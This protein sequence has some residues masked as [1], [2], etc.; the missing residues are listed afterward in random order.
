MGSYERSEINSSCT[1]F[2]SFE[3]IFSN[4]NSLNKQSH[5]ISKKRQFKSNNIPDDSTLRKELF[6]GFETFLCFYP[7]KQ[8][9]PYE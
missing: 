5:W 6:S 9:D 2:I 8:D 7:I 1:F 3:T 4:I